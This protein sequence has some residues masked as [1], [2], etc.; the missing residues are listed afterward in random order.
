MIV[1]KSV[2]PEYSV[3]AISDRYLYQPIN[4]QTL[5]R[6]RYDIT[7][8]ENLRVMHGIPILHSSSYDTLFRLEIS[9]SNSL[10]RRPIYGFQ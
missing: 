9:V 4:N 1:V 6:I 7:N 3:E 8:I 2:E 5:A 10:N